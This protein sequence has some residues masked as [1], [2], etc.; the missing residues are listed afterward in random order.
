[1]IYLASCYDQQRR[2]VGKSTTSDKLRVQPEQ[3]T[4]LAA[5]RLSP[6]TGSRPITITYSAGDS[7][8]TR[9]VFVIN[10]CPSPETLCNTSPRC[11]CPWGACDGV[12]VHEPDVMAH[13]TVVVQVATFLEYNTLYVYK[14]TVFGLLDTC[15]VCTVGGTCP[16]PAT[17]P[18]ASLA[19]YDLAAPTITP[20]GSGTY[21]SGGGQ[22]IIGMMTS[23]RVSSAAYTD[24][25]GC[26]LRCDIGCEV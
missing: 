11:V 6:F 10:P 23:V 26:D 19:V 16:N 22:Q 17:V 21:V 25:G 15:R 9:Y 2:I 14:K 13:P 20:R 18:P 5:S 12:G 7:S 4:T 3:P 1:L 8:V 24:P